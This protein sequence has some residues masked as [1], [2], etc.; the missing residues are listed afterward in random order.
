MGSRIN[1]CRFPCSYFIIFTVEKG[2]MKKQVVLNTMKELP[3]DFQL[4]ELIEKL[5][6]IQK[7]EEGLA[8]AK[9]GNV[10]SHKKAKQ[11]LLSKS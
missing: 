10:V 2:E 11:L 4:E 7:I 3:N 1:Q 8:D 5:L 9:K 6:V